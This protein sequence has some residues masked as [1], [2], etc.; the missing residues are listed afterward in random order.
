MKWSSRGERVVLRFWVSSFQTC[1]VGGPQTGI[2]NGSK[3]A[4]N[5]LVPLHPN[6]A[7]EVFSLHLKRDTSET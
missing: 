7:V 5:L 4:V 1:P 2:K 6:L 3:E